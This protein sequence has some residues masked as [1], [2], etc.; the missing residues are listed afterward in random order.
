M[1]EEIKKT[2]MSGGEELKKLVEEAL[3]KGIGPSSILNEA[4]IPGMEELGEK[5]ARKEIF[6]PELLFAARSMMEA[7][8][9]LE[10]HLAKNVEKGKGGKGRV[11]LGTVKGDIHSIG[12]NLV[13]IM[14]R[15]IGF[16]VEDIGVDIPPSDFVKKSEGADIVGLSCLMTTSLPYLEKTV[17]AL[18]ERGKRVIVGGAVVT[19]SFAERIGADAYAPDAATAAMKAKEILGR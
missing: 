5:F 19:S 1:L 18:K 9:V 3:S 4:L 17:K 11:V 6:V 14:M 13:S 7:I 2:L 12:K 8:K 10:P 15:G 16:E